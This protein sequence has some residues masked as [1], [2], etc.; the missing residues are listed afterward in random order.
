VTWR[1]AGITGVDAGVILITDPCYV[2]RDPDQQEY[3]PYATWSNLARQMMPE[4][5]PS[6]QIR[7]EFGAEV[8][9]V[10]NRFGGD[11]VYPVYIDVNEHGYVRA[12]MICFDGEGP[13]GRDIA[14]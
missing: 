12:A 8:G 7:N 13:V 11:G 2:V 5:E 6:Y 3:E 1:A 14:S 4:T 10:V 9:V